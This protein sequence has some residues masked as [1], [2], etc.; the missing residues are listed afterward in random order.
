[1]ATEGSLGPV[2]RVGPNRF[3]KALGNVRHRLRVQCAVA[4]VVDD[5]NSDWRPM[6]Y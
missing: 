4:G 6:W 3:E 5:W 1:M 2:A